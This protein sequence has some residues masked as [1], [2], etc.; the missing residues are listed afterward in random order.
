MRCV[1]HRKKVCT[2]IYLSVYPRVLNLKV[3]TTGR[4]GLNPNLK[5]TSSI[6]GFVKEKIENSP[7][8][9]FYLK[10]F[11][12]D[13]KKIYINAKNEHIHIILCISA[14]EPTVLFYDEIGY[15]VMV[16]KGIIYKIFH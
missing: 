14:K 3:W 9:E 1:I 15:Y 5:L 12:I 8:R 11:Y 6:G 13:K 2:T 10:G 16:K 4:D 7:W